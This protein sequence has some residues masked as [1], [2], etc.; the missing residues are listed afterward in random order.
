MVSHFELKGWWWVGDVGGPELVMLRIKQTHHRRD[1]KRPTPKCN[2][3]IVV[4]VGCRG[5]R[6][7]AHRILRGLLK[8][9]KG[10]T[11]L[12]TNAQ[13]TNYVPLTFVCCVTFHRMPHR[14][15]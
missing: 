9:E 10:N 11:G 3:L 14:I 13:R 5:E 2:R 12:C 4:F 1:I 8:P 7:R 6:T 15:L